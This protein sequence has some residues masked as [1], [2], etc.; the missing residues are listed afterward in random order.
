MSSR[1]KNTSYI[2]SVSYLIEKWIHQGISLEEIDKK[3]EELKKEKNFPENLKFISAYAEKRYGSSGCAFLDEETQETIVG[4]SGTN[5]QSGIVEGTKDL[6]VDALKLGITGMDEDCLYLEKPELFIKSLRMHGHLVTQVTGHSLGGAVA[7]YMAIYEDIPKV[8]TYNGA[9]LYLLSKG[10]KSRINQKAEE[11]KGTI[12]RYVSEYDPLNFISDSASG[13]YLG[14]EHVIYNK[15]G[16]AM[17]HFLEEHAECYKKV[18]NDEDIRNLYEQF[19]ILEEKY[20][21]T[22]EKLKN[23]WTESEKLIQ[24]IKR[25]QME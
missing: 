4:F 25:K 23:I 12:I 22:F 7:V 19:T 8:V 5:Y 3:I 16:H 1:V 18:E 20:P 2:A 10:D 21:E 13:F 17:H 6:L 11:Y 24:N 9:P 14:E 15:E